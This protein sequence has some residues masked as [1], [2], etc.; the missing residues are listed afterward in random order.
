M[1]YQSDEEK[2]FVRPSRYASASEWVAKGWEWRDRAWWKW[3][4]ERN[5]WLRVT[6]A[7][8]QPHEDVIKQPQDAQG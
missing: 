5:T 6:G 4:E 3:D 8:A 7:M 2:P 1:K